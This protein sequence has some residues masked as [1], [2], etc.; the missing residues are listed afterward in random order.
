V[1]ELY[2]YIVFPHLLGGFPAYFHLY[3]Y[4][5]LWPLATEEYKLSIPITRDPP[6]LR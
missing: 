1:L 3:M 2:L 4:Y 6:S 5:I